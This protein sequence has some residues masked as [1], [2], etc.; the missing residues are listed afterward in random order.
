MATA[1]I[2]IYQD[3]TSG[4]RGVARPANPGL[5]GRLLA[6]HRA[7]RARRTFDDDMQRLHETS[8]HLLDDLDI[9]D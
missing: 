4:Q 8:P 2:L 5:L 9:G 7:R 1:T 3:W 6:A